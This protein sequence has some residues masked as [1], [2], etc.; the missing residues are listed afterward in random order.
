MIEAL[1]G[2]I[3]LTSVGQEY[4]GPCRIVGC[5]WVGATVSGDEAELKGRLGTQNHVMWAATTDVGNTYLG[6]IWGPPGIH[7]PNGFRVSVL[8]GGKLLV[9]LSQ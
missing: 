9:Y 1:P 6:A 7:A 4:T 3:V 5:L 2:A 8:A